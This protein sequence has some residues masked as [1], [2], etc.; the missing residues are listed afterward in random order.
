MPDKNGGFTIYNINGIGALYYYI[1]LIKVF[2]YIK[3]GFSLKPYSLFYDNISG[4]FRFTVW[5][6][7]TS[8]RIAGRKSNSPI[9]VF[10]FKPVGLFD[11]I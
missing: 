4:K 3:N 9:K 11:M 1:S 2:A 5:F 10:S 7:G 6:S 8:G